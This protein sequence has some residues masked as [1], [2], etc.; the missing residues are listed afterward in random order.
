MKCD[1]LLKDISGN[2]LRLVEAKLPHSDVPFLKP[3]QHFRDIEC[4]DQ[5]IMKKYNLDLP[6]MIGKVDELISA[7]HTTL[8]KFKNGKPKMSKL[9]GTLQYIDDKANN[10]ERAL[11]MMSKQPVTQ[12]TRVIN[13]GRGPDASEWDGPN[14]FGLVPT[15]P[16]WSCWYRRCAPVFDGDRVYIVATITWGGAQEVGVVFLFGLL[17]VKNVCHACICSCSA[18]F[19]TLMITAT[20]GTS[21]AVTTMS[22]SSLGLGTM[23]H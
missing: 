9:A 10:L 23:K 8:D 19:N 11:D 2:D 22:L 1:R 16:A 6:S 14:P 13:C 18:L 15:D 5:A 4:T 21:M 12:G 20:M 17:I 7:A 3:D